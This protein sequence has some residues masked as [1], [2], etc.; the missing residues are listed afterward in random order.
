MVVSKE[1]ADSHLTYIHVQ[2]RDKVQEGGHT[3]VVSCVVQ[4]EASAIFIKFRFITEKLK[5]ELPSRRVDRTTGRQ[6][7]TKYHWNMEEN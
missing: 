1:G 5:V 3:L 4:I 2:H 7:A 6:V